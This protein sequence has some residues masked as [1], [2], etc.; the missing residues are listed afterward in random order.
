VE[1]DTFYVVLQVKWRKIWS[2]C[3]APKVT[4]QAR[5]INWEK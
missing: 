4:A 5:K 2:W 3:W 1:F